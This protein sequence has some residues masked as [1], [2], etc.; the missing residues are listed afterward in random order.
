MRI[1]LR[2]RLLERE[3]KKN[4]IEG[5]MQEALK[6][7]ISDL[8]INPFDIVEEVKKKISEKGKPAVIVFFG[9][10]GSGK[11]TTI[12]KVVSLILKNKLK[13]V[14]AASDTFRAASIEQIQKHATKLGV[15]VIKH[16]YGA[17]AAAVSFD[18]IQYAKANDIDIVLIDT[19]GRMHTEVNLMREMEKICK[20]SK[21]DFKIFIGE[22]TVGNDMIEQAKTFNERIGIDGIILTK[23]DVDEKGGSAISAS[24]I[25]KK[26]ILLLGTGQEYSDLEVFNKEKI[27]KLLGFN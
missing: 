20:V 24:Y 7:S 21:P 13:C 6:N 5:I 25:T 17:D 18:A 26:P 10:N 27:I 3:I 12:A 16:D 9:I 15:K 19:A 1:K 2:E 22:S 23:A 14:L 8:L 11:T 4:E